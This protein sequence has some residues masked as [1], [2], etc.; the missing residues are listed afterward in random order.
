MTEEENPS[1]NQPPVSVTRNATAVI[2][3]LD[4]TLVDTAPDIAAALNRMLADHG[5]PAL[6]VARVEALT[7]EGA[8]VLVEKAYLTL[9]TPVSPQRARADMTT[10]LE[11]YRQA[12]VEHSAL[13]PQARETLVAL[14]AAGVRLGICTN[15]PQELADLVLTR[16]GVAELFG[17]VVGGDALPERKPHPAPLQRA[18]LELGTDP[19]E[20]LFVGDTL[21]DLEC[22]RNAT[23][24]V[25]IV[26]W[27]RAADAVVDAGGRVLRRFADLP[28]LAGVS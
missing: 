19:G 10:Y 3:D 1:V 17:T 5:L 28:A 22:A 13:Y 7:G 11:Y 24:P 15:K 16:L 25:A 6:G 8:L 2:F 4:G 14:R 12:P 26:G 9:G 20:A 21:I 23:V 27:G 18:L